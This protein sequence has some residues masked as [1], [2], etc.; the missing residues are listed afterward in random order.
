VT[1][2]Y[3]REEV[4]ALRLRSPRSAGS[5]VIG[6]SRTRTRASQ[7]VEIADFREY[8]PGDDVGRIDWNIT[9]RVGKPF[10]RLYVEER[11]FPVLFMVDVSAS[12][13]SGAVHAVI[14]ETAA[15]LASAAVWDGHSTAL[16]RFTDRVHSY[17]PSAA[18]PRQ[19]DRLIAELNQ[20]LSQAASTD[21]ARVLTYLNFLALRRSLVFL[22]SDFL[23]P[24]FEAPLLRCA[25]RHEIVPIAVEDPLT[26]HLE[27]R[28]LIDVRDPESGHSMQIDTSSPHVRAAWAQL[29]AARRQR[30]VDTFRKAGLDHLS[31]SADSP[32]AG[33]LAAFLKDRAH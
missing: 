6:E 13:Q 10:V 21:L 19:L 24:D 23:C 31:L 15:R 28:G 18:G 30:S 3:S 20:P 26:S 2:V 11:G 22:L 32:P 1:R 9:A 8:T 7:G 33:I 12:T 17:L 29:I 25:H 5:A 4:R 16:M 14:A 27:D